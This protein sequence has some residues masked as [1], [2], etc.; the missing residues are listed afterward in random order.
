[1]TKENNSYLKIETRL[2]DV[3]L[4]QLQSLIKNT[5]QQCIA[6]ALPE[7][8]RPEKDELLTV[9][10]AADFLNLTV[11]TIYTKVSKNELPFMKR[12]KRLY[13]SKKELTE[14]LKKGRVKT[15][16]EIEAEANEYL[17]NKKKGGFN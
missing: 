15:N 8:N 17:A 6:D 1:M 4:E 13:F 5:V 2:I 7:Q 12:S 14:Y 11:P 16:D 9:Q 10:Q 3:T